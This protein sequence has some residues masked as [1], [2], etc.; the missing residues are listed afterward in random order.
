[1]PFPAGSDI[2]VVLC[3]LYLYSTSALASVC[4]WAPSSLLYIRYFPLAVVKNQGGGGD[5]RGLAF[6]PALEAVES[7]LAWP[8]QGFFQ[9][10]QALH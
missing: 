1:M 2:S 10:V 4:I 6:L 5:L 3:C 7:T 9:S 8:E